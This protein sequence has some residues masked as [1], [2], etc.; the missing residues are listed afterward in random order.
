MNFIDVSKAALKVKEK[1]E[2]V[3]YKGNPFLKGI[4][5]NEDTCTIN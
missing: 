3:F 1:P 4:F 5:I 2:K